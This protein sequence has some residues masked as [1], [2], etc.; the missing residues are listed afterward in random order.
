MIGP[1][2][3]CDKVVFEEPM[4][5]HTSF[6]AGG[7]AR[8]FAEPKDTEE[9]KDLISYASNNKLPYLVMGNGSN[10][11]FSDSGYD[12]LI[13]KLGSAF[14]DICIEEERVEVQSGALMDA[15]AKEIGEHS[16]TGFEGL[17]GIP[18]S[19]GGAVAMNAGA[20]GYETGHI[21]QEVEFL[22]EKGEI[23]RLPVEQLEL[24]YRHSIFTNHPYVILK[25]IFRLNK[26][27]KADILE[28][29]EDF[30]RRRRTNQPLEYASAGSTFKRPEGF[31]AG[32]LIQEAGLK[33]VCV[34]DACVSEKHAGFIV[35]K[36]EACAGDI[37]Q[38]ICYVQTKV[39]AN[40]GVR[41][42]PEVKLIGEF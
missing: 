30:G 36:G 33:G 13:I 21:L 27:N 26:D 2:K 22:N 35:N 17:S 32:K 12:G 34:G 24:G 28:R 37:Y 6:R 41:L 40:S 18:G 8:I 39:Y 16:L 20:Y 15:V 9:L 31:F 5:K 42:E 14:S 38:L 25:A 29:M 10:L 7:K 4:A 11:L 23:A 3:I 19:I 1:E